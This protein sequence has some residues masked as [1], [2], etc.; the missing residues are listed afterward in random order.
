VFLRIPI[1]IFE[2]E[3]I[4]YRKKNILKVRRFSFF[5]NSMHKNVNPATNLTIII[6]A[7]RINKNNSSIYLHNKAR[8]HVNPTNIL[9]SDS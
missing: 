3:D 4:K 9:D 5:L 2:F 8:I 1:K 7:R 6:I